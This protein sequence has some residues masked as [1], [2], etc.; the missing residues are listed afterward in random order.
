[1]L[2]LLYLAWSLANH[3]PVRDLSFLTHEM[4]ELYEVTSNT[5]VN[6]RIIYSSRFLVKTPSVEKKEGWCLL[7]LEWALITGWETMALEAL[8]LNFETSMKPSTKRLL[9]SPYTLSFCHLRC[10]NVC[11]SPNRME[12]QFFQHQKWT[13]G[14]QWWYLGPF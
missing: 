12:S 3:F 4:G 9:W 14:N 7:T 5:V 1:M 6:I 11:W 2:K 13:G 8:P 10:V